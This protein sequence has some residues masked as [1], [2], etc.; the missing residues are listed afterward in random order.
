[1]PDPFHFLAEGIEPTSDL[2]QSVK[3]LKLKVADSTLL[4]REAS[5]SKTNFTTMFFAHWNP[6]NPSP[7]TSG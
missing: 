2:F 5:W 6:L 3:I 7:G 1:M 4:N